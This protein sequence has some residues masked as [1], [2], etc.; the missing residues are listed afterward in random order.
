MHDYWANFINGPYVIS[1]SNAA[2]LSSPDEPRPF[3]T[4][5]GRE[6]LDSGVREYTTE[7]RHGVKQSEYVSSDY[8]VLLVGNQ[9]LVVKGNASLSST[10]ELKPLPSTIPAMIFPDEKDAD[11]RSR[12][13]LK[14]LDTTENYRLTGYVVIGLSLLFAFL[15]FVFVKKA[16]GYVRN[17]STHPVVKRV[18]GWSDAA[19][20]VTLSEREMSTPRFKRNGV[21]FTDTFV[22]VRGFFTF[23]LLAWNHLLWAYRKQTTTRYYFI[24]PVARSQ[25]AIMHF[26][27]G[28]V[29]W[30]AGKKTVEE[31]LGFASNQAPWAVLGYSSELE[32][33]WSKK[34]SDFVAG[35]E[36]R[37]EEMSRPYAPPPPV[38]HI[39]LGSA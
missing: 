34:N 7:T 39:D 11:L 22:I 17:I 33:L 27:G 30:R 13:Y 21:L 6:I 20:V 10:G 24:V 1:E 38:P 5:T 3:V 29:S 23:N 25:E 19:D 37:R 32:K 4:V 12:L 2:V 36:A 35:V 9:A 15:S 31:A 26:Y 8:S 18:E 16:L 14:M 28:S